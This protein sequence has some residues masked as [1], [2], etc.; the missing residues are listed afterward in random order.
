MQ[1]S[2][3]DWGLHAWAIFA[4]FGLAIAYSTHRKGRR[5]AGQPAVPPAAR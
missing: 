5:D 2:Y 1:Y 3:F 4:V